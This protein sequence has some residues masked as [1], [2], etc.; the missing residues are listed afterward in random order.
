ME[1]SFIIIPVDTNG[2][3]SERI[4]EIR[5]LTESAGAE[6]A[7]HLCV[8]INRIVPATYIGSGKA[9]EIKSMCEELNCD[10][11]IFDG[12][13]TPSQ[14]LNLSEAL[15]D[16]K[17]IDRTT[18]ILD[19]FASRA[20]SAEGKVQVEL[21]QLRYIYPRL[22][23]KGS[24][25]SRLG[26]GIGTRGPGESKLES[27]R[28]HI[29]RRINYLE[30]RLLELEKRRQLQGERR[31]KNGVL[32]ISLI[33][34]TNTGKSTLLNVLTGSDVLAEN[35][36]FATLDPTTR[37]LDL[38]EFTVLLSDTVGFIK[39]IPTTLIEAFKSTLETAVESDLVLIVCDALTDWPIQLDTTNSMLDELNCTANR[40]LVFNKC[41][42]ITDFS[43]YP[44]EAIFISAKE[45]KGLGGLILKIRSYFETNYTKLNLVIPYSK[46]S[47]FHSLQ[48]YIENSSLEYCNDCLKAEI[49]VNNKFRNRFDIFK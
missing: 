8:K 17:V 42:N 25:L 47:V 48:N 23:G 46:L 9:S 20:N 1:I 29:R 35:K 6:V 49:I 36:L 28:R 16:I 32:K 3:H 37:K 2:E 22:K 41:E 38:G 15:G 26:G 31:T 10:L 27:D 13:L 43:Q 24:A 14:T 33:G 39:N 30:E 11:V 34:Y 44:S 21:A 7:G 5:S 40:L 18:L 19:I 12:D 4:N 45:K